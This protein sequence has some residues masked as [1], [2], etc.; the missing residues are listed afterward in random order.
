VSDESGLQRVHDLD[1]EVQRLA[2]IVESLRTD[3][4]QLR[5]GVEDLRQWREDELQ[6]RREAQH[7]PALPLPRARDATLSQPAVL[8][9][10]HKGMEVHTADDVKLGK[11]QEVWFGTDP[12]HSGEAWDEELCSRLEVRQ[13]GSALYVP[14]YAIARVSG[15]WVI[16]TMDADSVAEHNWHRRPLW[17]PVEGEVGPLRPSVTEA[18]TNRKLQ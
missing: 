17:I 15:R 6:A 4:T 12:T 8:G 11:A 14:A 3:L 5:E 10:I 7:S 1:E 13:A 16:L 18:A 2:A 9:Q